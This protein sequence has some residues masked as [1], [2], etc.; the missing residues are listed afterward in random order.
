MGAMDTLSAAL[1]LAEKASLEEDDIKS[2]GLSWRWYTKVR[3]GGIPNP[4]I[5]N[6]DALRQL[7][8]RK[9]TP[10]KTKRG[11]TAC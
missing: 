8:E 3:T 6:V 9:L 5:K 7:A 1:A 11:R 2:I 4:G 10:T